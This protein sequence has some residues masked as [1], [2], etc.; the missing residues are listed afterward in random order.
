LDRPPTH[1]THKVKY[2]GDASWDFHLDV[3]YKSVDL[4][5]ILPHYRAR[6]QPVQH[7]M[8]MFVGSDSSPVKLKVCRNFSQ[9]KFYLEVQADTSDVTVWLPSDFKGQIHHTG[10]ATF[11]AGFINRIMRNVRINEQS[12]AEI[13]NEDDVVVYTKGHITFRMWDIQTC[14]PEKSHKESLKRM[15]GCGRKTPE[16]AIDWDFLLKD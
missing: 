8:R 12:F 16:T 10:K 5:L 9:S 2:H 7:R 4:S 1:G 15:F 3:E 13:Y 6:N 11:S 14:A